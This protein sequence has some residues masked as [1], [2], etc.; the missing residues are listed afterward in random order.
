MKVKL[1]LVLM[2]FTSY[3]FACINEYRTLLSGK[4]IYK[5]VTGEDAWL[6]NINKEELRK[7]SEILFDDYQ[8]TGSIEH[9][10][11]YAA[12]LIYLGEYNKAKKIYFEIENKKPNLYT[13][14]SNLGTL[15]ELVGKPDSALIWIRKSIRLNPESHEGSEWIHIKILEYKISKNNSINYSILGLDFGQSELPEN[16]KK[17]DL[18]KLEHEITHQLFERTMFVKPKD[19]IVGNIYFDLGNI[20]AQT[21]DLESALK[22]YAAAK[23][24]G[25]QSNLI[26]IRTEKFENIIL[27]NQVKDFIIAILCV[28]GFITV[29]V[30]IFYIT[31]KYIKRKYMW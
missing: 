4:T 17:Y 10:S 19:E 1:L 6:R 29:L 22:C 8:R 11:D 25:F 27:K 2:L 28:G 30:I 12:N 31:Y 3:S 16:L 18:E 9:L 7:K 23:I 21:Y 26:N 14:A 24:Y 5:N 20:L 15:Y 13:T